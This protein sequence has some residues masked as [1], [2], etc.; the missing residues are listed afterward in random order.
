[1]IAQV[2]LEPPLLLLWTCQPSV[3]W[4]P[5]HHQDCRL[6]LQE[7]LQWKAS[8]TL[9]GL[10]MSKVGILRLILNA[11]CSFS[12]LLSLHWHITLLPVC[13]NDGNDPE[14]M[15]EVQWLNYL[16]Q[17]KEECCRVS[18]LLTIFSPI[19]MSENVYHFM[20]L[21][22]FPLTVFRWQNHF[23]WCITQCMQNEHHK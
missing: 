1:M 20:N 16:Y 3:A 9:T 17:S 6:L 13:K 19:L 8:T 10:M 15:L 12:K 7:T 21:D 18:P 22:A 5:W 14:Y 11:K 4:P 23:W 2:S